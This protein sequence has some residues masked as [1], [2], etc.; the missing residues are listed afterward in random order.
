MRVVHRYGADGQSFGANDFALVERPF[1]DDHID[2][3]HGAASFYFGKAVAHIAGCGK[4]RQQ[5]DAEG[6]TEN[7]PGFCGA[8]VAEIGK[9]HGVNGSRCLSRNGNCEAEPSIGFLESGGEL[10]Q[11]AV[12]VGEADVVSGSLP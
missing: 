7:D 11:D 10:P 5:A 8:E 9:F 4:G 3:L 1:C 6:N 2:G 12:V